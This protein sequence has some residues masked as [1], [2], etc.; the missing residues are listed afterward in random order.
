MISAQYSYP[1]QA[2]VSMLKSG[3]LLGWNFLY[4]KFSSILYGAILKITSEENL[5]K[6][7]LI[8]SKEVL[9]H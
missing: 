5:A 2:I 4:D 7:I 1:D 9:F 8:E 6:E 3:D